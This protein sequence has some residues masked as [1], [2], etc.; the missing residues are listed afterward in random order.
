MLTVK[1]AG[2]V[3]VPAAGRPGQKVLMTGQGPRK[4]LRSLIHSLVQPQK[5]NI[6]FFSL[7]LK[8]ENNTRTRFFHL[9][10]FLWQLKVGQN[11]HKVKNSEVFWEL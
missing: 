4:S 10:G 6:S 9:G 7:G 5:N 8:E 1:W 2:L 3:G 11:F